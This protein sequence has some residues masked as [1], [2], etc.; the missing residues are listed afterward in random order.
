MRSKCSGIAVGIAVLFSLV[1]G[2]AGPNLWTDGT[3]VSTGKTNRGRTR[4][5]AKLALKGRGFV[6]PKRW[7]ERGF[8]YGVDELVAAVQRAAE[9]VRGRSARVKLGVADFSPKRGGRSTWHASHQSGRDVDLIFYTADEK[10]R[11]LAPAPED[12]IHFDDEGVAYE[13]PKQPYVDASWSTRRFDTARNWKLIESLL[14]DPTIRL[15]WVFVSDGLKQRLLAYANK[16]KRPAW[17]VAYARVVLRQPGDA[18]PHDDHFHVR[19]Y[20]NRGD[21]MY[22]C[23][24]R[25]VVWHHEK[26]SF[27]YAGLEHYDPVMWRLMTGLP[28][29]LSPG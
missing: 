14:S 12:M 19:I 4:H 24:D 29:L 10:G 3:S 8:Q 16:V 17:V 15:Q 27:K 1:T 5:P 26:K 20:C 11:P 18:P 9:K 25:G 2:C 23:V 28:T 13:K 21:R 6:V 22:G 7:R